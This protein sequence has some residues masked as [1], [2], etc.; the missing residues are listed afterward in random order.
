[1]MKELQKQY[2]A[3]VAII[4]AEQEEKIRKLSHESIFG[5]DANPRM[6]SF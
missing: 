3:F 5:T 1:M 2:E 4:N 6:A